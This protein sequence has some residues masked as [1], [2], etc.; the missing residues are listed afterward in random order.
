[1]RLDGSGTAVHLYE[2]VINEWNKLKSD[3]EQLKVMQ[4]AIS[5]AGQMVR[6]ET[7]LAMLKDHNAPKSVIT[8]AREFV[9]R[10]MGMRAKMPRQRGDERLLTF[11]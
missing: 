5:R 10:D 2:T 4:R 9:I 11:V 8:G 7:R 6:S 1:L 3:S